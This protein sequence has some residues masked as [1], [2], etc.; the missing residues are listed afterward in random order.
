M[1]RSTSPISTFLLIILALVPLISCGGS[2]D[3]SKETLDE[4]SATLDKLI[5]VNEL[6][7]AVAKVSVVRPRARRISRLAKP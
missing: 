6:P 5:R 4:L 1:K 3:L 2:N 7:G